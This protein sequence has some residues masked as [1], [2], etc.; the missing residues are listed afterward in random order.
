MKYS[1]AFITIAT[2]DLPSLVRFYSRLLQQ[3]PSP[4]IPNSYAEFTLIDL[5]LG[6][7]VPKSTHQ[8]E[9]SASRRGCFSICLEIENLE[10]TIA[11]LQTIDYP[12][13][14]EISIASH[15]RETYIY[16]PDGNR[17]I[18]HQGRSSK[19]PQK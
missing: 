11:Y 6:I 15:G 14:P 16:D 1:K 13:I 12:Y 4:Y 7:F 10:E 3:Q 8:E 17:L 9:F 2:I 18:L 5:R 19:Y